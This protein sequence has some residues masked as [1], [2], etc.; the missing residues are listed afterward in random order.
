MRIIKKNKL[1]RLVLF[2]GIFAV[3]IIFILVCTK[4]ILLKKQKLLE[5]TN[6]YSNLHTTENAK[7]EERTAQELF[8]NYYE[9][10]EEK[11]GQMTLEEKISQM[12]IVRCP[13]SGAIDIVSNYQPGGY[14]LFARDFENKT[15]QETINMIEQ[16]QNKSKIP[17]IIAVDEEGGKVCR[18]SL[19]S[20]LVQNKFKSPQEL[21]VEGGF[22]KIYTDA[23][24]KS[25]L[26]LS[27]GINLN[28]APVA[29]VSVN[30]EDY[31]YKRTFGKDANETSKYIQTVVKAMKSQNI[32]CSLK[33]F[34]GYGNNKDSHT[35][36]TYDNRDLQTFENSDFLPFK[37]G[38]E[39]GA[40]TILVSHNII[41][42]ID[43][44]NPASLSK[45]IHELLRKELKFTG[46]IITDDLAMNG[47]KKIANIEELAII[48]VNAEN[49]LIITS[50]FKDQRKAIINAVKSNRIDEQT[51]NKAVKRII[52]YKYYM[53]LM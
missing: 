25:K 35:D 29:D 30:Q 41:S 13:S 11:L 19:N 40:Q 39:T 28:L 12:F 37:A 22:D 7:P 9:K 17:M 42:E 47:A 45:D 49:D 52:A 10:A 14:I 3:A 43:P 53:G 6:T 48:A 24:E 16:F 26:L 21:Y 36:I 23:V 15:K 44:K 1:I 46:L 34:P 4:S 33:H 38:I 31:I 50:D 51:I 8:E 20:N 2:I 5:Q 18:V 27:L 32:A